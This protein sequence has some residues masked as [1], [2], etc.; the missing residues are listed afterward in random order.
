ME[1]EGGGDA[2]EESVFPDPGNGVDVAGVEV[3]AEGAEG[4]GIGLP[5][6]LV[7]QKKKV[8]K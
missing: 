6:L 5:C 8:S 2:G 4:G 3:E 7:Q 1:E